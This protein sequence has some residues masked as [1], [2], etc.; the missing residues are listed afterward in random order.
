MILELLGNTEHIYSGNEE[1]SVMRR[2]GCVTP[3]LSIPP[4]LTVGIIIAI[5]GSLLMLALSLLVCLREIY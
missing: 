5:L 1:C 3:V 4:K 2:R